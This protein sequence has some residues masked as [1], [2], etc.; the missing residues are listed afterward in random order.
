MSISHIHFVNRWRWSLC[1]CNRFVESKSLILLKYDYALITLLYE[2]NKEMRPT[3]T[4][5]LYSP[6]QKMLSY[7]FPLETLDTPC[8]SCRWQQPVSLLSILAIPNKSLIENNSQNVQNNVT[9]QEQV[10]NRLFLHI[11]YYHVSVDMVSWN[12]SEIGSYFSIKY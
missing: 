1:I 7:F 12:W 10:V 11:I 5:I 6:F 8:C 3:S 4:C 2:K 9:T